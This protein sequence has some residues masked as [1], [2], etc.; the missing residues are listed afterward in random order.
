MNI[1]LRRWGVDRLSHF[2][3]R[4][5][6]DGVTTREAFKRWRGDESNTRDMADLFGY[7]QKPGI[8]PITVLVG[9]DFHDDLGLVKYN[10]TGVAHNTL[11]AF[12]EGWTPTLRLC[13]GI[14]FDREGRLVAHAFPKFFNR[15]EHPETMTLPR[16]RSWTATE[17]LDGHLGIVFSCQRNWHATTRGSFDSPSSKLCADIMIREHLRRKWQATVAPDITPLVEIIDPATKVHIDYEGKSGL[18]LIG[19]YNRVTLEDFPHDRLVKLGHQLGIPVTERYA[20][21]DLDAL[22]ALM[23]DL[24]VRGREG[25]VVR[26]DDGLRVKLKFASYINLMVE[27][28]LSPKYLM[29][30][31]MSGNAE[32]MIKNLDYEVLAR[33][34]EM[35]G[36]IMRAQLMPGDAKAKA[37]Y[38][39]GLVPPEECTAY[40][41][42]VCREFVRSLARA[43]DDKR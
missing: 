35:L 37:R 3:L 23:D 15:G 16:D 10:Y 42:T 21:E 22:E 9:V 31:I 13:R 25:V 11:H 8:P 27:A 19:A 34:N 40:Y 4:L 5:I 29:Q 14:V 20:G 33:A 30:R 36:R 41:R 7:E 2:T 6:A 28:K 18:V 38:L 24:S 32:R 26:F 17:K 12:P 39:H 43:S 1:D